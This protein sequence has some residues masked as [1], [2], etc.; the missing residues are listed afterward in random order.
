[1]NEPVPAS[2][3]SP[4][5]PADFRAAVTLDAPMPAGVTQL[6]PGS[7]EPA[8]LD[9]VRGH[10]VPRTV[11]IT[12]EPVRLGRSAANTLVLSDD[13]VSRAHAEVRYEDGAYLISDLGSSNGTYVKLPPRAERELQ[14]GDCVRIGREVLRVSV[15]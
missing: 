3:N 8:T 5:N 7:V 4:R 11:P 13:R 14:D 1:M 15:S 9:V 2:Q 12:G 10:A 6:V